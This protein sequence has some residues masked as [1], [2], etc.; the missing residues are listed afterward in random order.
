MLVGLGVLH[1]W[2]VILPVR[3]TTAAGVLRWSRVAFIYIMTTVSAFFTFRQ[4]WGL[5]L[6]FFDAVAILTAA[7]ACTGF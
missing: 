1:L 5:R 6:T 4:G 7:E 3:A 2:T